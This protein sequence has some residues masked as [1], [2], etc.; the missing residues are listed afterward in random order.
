MPPPLSA[1]A[2]SYAALRLFIHDVYAARR[3]P[4]MTLLIDYLLIII[5]DINIDIVWLREPL[6]MP[7]RRRHIVAY[8]YADDVTLRHA[9]L[10]AAASFTLTLFSLWLIA[11]RRHFS[12]QYLLPMHT[13][14]LHPPLIGHSSDACFHYCFSSILSFAAAFA[15]FY[16]CRRCLL[17]TLSMVSSSAESCFANFVLSFDLLILLYCRHCRCFFFRLPP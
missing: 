2:L 1:A 15:F 7:L 5:D 12:C 9:M 8:A 16:H 3:A 17:I 4:R 6:L 11:F 10:I 13:P 14:A